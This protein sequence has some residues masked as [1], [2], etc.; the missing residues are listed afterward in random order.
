[1]D[2]FC[3]AILAQRLRGSLDFFSF[4]YTFPNGA[5]EPDTTAF[6]QIW[7]DLVLTEIITFVL[8]LYVLV[9][10][11]KRLMRKQMNKGI[12]IT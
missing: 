5:K 1:M 8:H 9:R 6:F 11:Q 10:H 4:A 3:A 12:T 7:Y 2:G